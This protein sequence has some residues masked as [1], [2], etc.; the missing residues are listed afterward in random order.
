[1]HLCVRMPIIGNV[2][3]TAT[4]KTCAWEI[5][6][7]WCCTVFCMQPTGHMGTAKY[8]VH[9]YE[10]CRYASKHDPAPTFLDYRLLAHHFCRRGLPRAHLFVCR[11]CPRLDIRYSNA[12]LVPAT[13]VM[14]PCQ[15][16]VMQGERRGPTNPLLAIWSPRTAHRPNFG[17]S[18]PTE[19][20]ST[21]PSGPPSP[22]HHA[23][24]V[25]R[26]DTTCCRAAACI[27]LLLLV[28]AGRVTIAML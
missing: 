24:P 16:H 14:T 8:L 18:P 20:R 11:P 22:G 10:S 9:P 4:G 6:R 2:F 27:T 7:V 15:A 21:F 25:D 13:V 3:W 12:P 19:L 17:Y 5:T 23:Q 28:P 1:M 26:K